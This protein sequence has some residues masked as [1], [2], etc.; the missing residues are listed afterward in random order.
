MFD[1][2]RLSFDADKQRRDA[3]ARAN[4]G[5]DCVVLYVSSEHDYAAVRLPEHGK[6]DYML[7]KPKEVIQ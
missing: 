2:A 3:K 5:R 4:H 1:T 6:Y 7:V